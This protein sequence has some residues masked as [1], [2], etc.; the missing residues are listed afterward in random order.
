[1]KLSGFLTSAGINILIC[2]VLSI[3]YSI[4][5][6]QPGHAGVYF[7]QRIS[8]VQQAQSHDPLCF[9]RF[10]PSTSWIRKAWETSE[11]EIFAIGGLDAVVFLRIVV[12]RY[13]F[14]LIVHVYI[15][16]FLWLL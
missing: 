7:G 16:I 3:L 11:E 10:V 1:M 15:Y 9:D 4:L 2:I 12:F 6:K 14:P 13:F 5:R 8:Q